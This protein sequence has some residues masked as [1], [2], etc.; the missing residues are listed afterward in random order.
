M[1][2]GGYKEYKGVIRGVGGKGEGSLVYYNRRGVVRGR[3]FGLL[4]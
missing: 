3:E 1:E 2:G 4:Q